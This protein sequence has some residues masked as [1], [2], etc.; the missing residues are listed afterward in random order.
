MMAKGLKYFGEGAAGGLA[1]GLED[2][3]KGEVDGAVSELG[4]QCAPAGSVA[5]GVEEIKPP[6]GEALGDDYPRVGRLISHDEAMEKIRLYSQRGLEGIVV[7]LEGEGLSRRGSCNVKQDSADVI[8]VSFHW[9]DGACVN[10]NLQRAKEEP[11]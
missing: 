9:P 1:E 11:Q 6:P 8:E 5:G 3:I 4:E 10:V 7:A 2:G